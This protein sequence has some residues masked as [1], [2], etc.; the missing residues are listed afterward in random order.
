MEIKPQHILTAALLA[1]GAYL[2]SPMVVISSVALWGLGS[3]E[4]VLNQK[5][6]D[7]DIGGMILRMEKIEKS[8]S[9]LRQ[10][11]SNVADR[12]KTILGEV[13]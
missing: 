3:A 7:A 1:L 12:A 5:K 4:T 9:D 10:D 2:H 6:R 13:Y 8:H 11:I